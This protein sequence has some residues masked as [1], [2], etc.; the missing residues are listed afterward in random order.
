LKPRIIL[1]TAKKLGLD[2][3]AVT[4]HNSIKGALKTKELNKD[5]NFKVIIGS[6]I[7][8]DKGEILAYYLNND[9][10]SRN[11]FEVIDEIKSQ[12]GISAVAHPFRIV[13][14]A[15]FKQPLKDLKGKID[16]IEIFN[17]R[18]LP[19]ENK[20]S[21]AAAKKL[22]ITGI[23]SSDAHFAFDIGNGYTIFEENLRKAI[24]ENKTKVDGT[25]KFALLSGILGSL[26]KRIISKFSSVRTNKVQIMS[27]KDY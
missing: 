6:E 19:G 11:I 25:I 20:K 21:T 17:S 15:R 23:G 13:P 8:T 24:N 27:K 10:K 26:H 9:I 22:G 1:K 5:K 4:D 2:G 14:W 18:T 12:D 3:I 7:K 16:A